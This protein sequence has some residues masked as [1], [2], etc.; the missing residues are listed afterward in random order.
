MWIIVKAMKV[1]PP[2]Y[3]YFQ[4]QMKL[5]SWMP[6]LLP[7]TQ[8]IFLIWSNSLKIESYLFLA[9]FSRVT[10]HNNQTT[11]GIFPT[12]AL[13]RKISCIPTVFRTDLFIPAQLC[14]FLCSLRTAV[15]Q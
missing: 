10:A 8:E 7:H 9:V 4:I 11:V 12:E 5:I 15:F 3:D 2:I 14:T 6:V 1:P 13:I